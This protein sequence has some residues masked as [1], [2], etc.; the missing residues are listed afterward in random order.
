MNCIG[1]GKGIILLLRKVS[2]GKMKSELW[3]GLTLPE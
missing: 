2:S 1:L 3:M